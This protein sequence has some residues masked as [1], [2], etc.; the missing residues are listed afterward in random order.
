MDFEFRMFGMIFMWVGIRIS[1]AYPRLSF[2]EFQLTA[3]IYNLAQYLQAESI[4]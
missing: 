3:R 4:T 2:Q 1:T